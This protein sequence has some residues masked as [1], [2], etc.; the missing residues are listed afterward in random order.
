MQSYY[1]DLVDKDIKYIRE[2]IVFK[3]RKKKW[4]FIG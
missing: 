2:S 1:E 3:G 4:D